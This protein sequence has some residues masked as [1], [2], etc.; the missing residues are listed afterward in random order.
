M[1]EMYVYELLLRSNYKKSQIK[2][3]QIKRDNICIHMSRTSELAHTRSH[4]FHPYHYSH[5]E[6]YYFVPP[7]AGHSDC[8]TMVGTIQIVVVVVVVDN[9]KNAAAVVVAVHGALV[10]H[11]NQSYL[12]GRCH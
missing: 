3:S 6:T 8:S 4:H 10:Q 12:A 5:V 1:C 9:D 11:H 2:Q 7:Y